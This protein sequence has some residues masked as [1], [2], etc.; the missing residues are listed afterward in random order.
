MAQ[1]WLSFDEIQQ[2]FSCGTADARRRV[3]ANQWERRRCSDG[4]VRAQVPSDV[5]YDFFMLR[6][7]RQPESRPAPVNEFEANAGPVRPV[8]TIRKTAER[9][10]ECGPQLDIFSVGRASRPSVGLERPGVPFP[11]SH[12]HAL[13]VSASLRAA[14]IALTASDCRTDGD[15]RPTMVTCTTVQK[16]YAQLDQ[17]LAAR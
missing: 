1:V 16:C 4:L 14:P 6:Y 8:S 3:V 5:A 17:R 10:H 7:R 13:L 15:R 11:T 9:M 12:H 2:L